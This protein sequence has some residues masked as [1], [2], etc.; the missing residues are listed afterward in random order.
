MLHKPLAA[1][2][3][4]KRFE[5][6]LPTHPDI[7]GMRALIFVQEGKNAEADSIIRAGIAGAYGS[8]GR[9]G[10]AGFGSSIAILHGKIRDG[11]RM[12]ALTIPD[13]APE[14]EKRAIQLGVTLD[15]AWIQAYLLGDASAARATVKRAMSAVPVESVAAPDRPWVTLLSIAFATRDVAAARTYAANWE[16]DVKPTRAGAAKGSSEAVRGLVAMTEGKYKDAAELFATADK[17]DLGPAEIGPFRAQALDLANQPDSAIAEFERYTT[18][19]QPYFSTQRDHLAGTHRRL[20]EL[21][22]AKGN[23]AKAIDHY[24]KFVELWK[25]ADPELQPKVKAARARIEELKKKGVKG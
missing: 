10:A 7:A 12:E 25:D 11:L 5:K 23:A 24:E 16:R 18:F 2:S 22:D 15:S 21:Y 17:G 13:K 14:A 9:A 20:G 6:R 1:E 4:L 3:T 8:I 19:V